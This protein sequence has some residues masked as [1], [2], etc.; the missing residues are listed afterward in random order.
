MTAADVAA[1]RAALDATA[2]G[3]RVVRFDVATR[4]LHWTTAALVLATA[5]TGL[6]LYV[7]A[8]S[9][10]V[11]R[12]DLVRDVHVLCGLASVAPLVASYAGPWRGAVRRDVRRLA[13]WSDADVVWIR[14]L[15]RRGRAGVGKFN[16]GQK[17]NAVFVASA[18]VVM[19]MTG[20][21]MRWFDPFPLSWR[22]GATFVHDWIGIALWI[23]IT[24]H[25]AKA[26]TEPV[27]LRGMVRGWMPVEWVRTSHP[28][29]FDE[30]LA[31]S[32]E[33][34]IRIRTDSAAGSPSRRTS[35]DP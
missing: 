31:E 33:K 10:L 30:L 13:R 2:L 12:R 32:A 27:A 8:L 15:G 26:I 7:G 1:D 25:I 28:V 19:A 4:L 29:W 22:T 20:S 3:P 14:S 11:G 24:G 34:S 35:G 18:M 16:A 9:G 17:A 6:V 5:V 23:A 21:I